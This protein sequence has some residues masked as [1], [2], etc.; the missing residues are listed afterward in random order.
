MYRAILLSV[1]LALPSAMAQ[2][3][4]PRLF[5]IGGRH[6]TANRE[7]AFREVKGRKLGAHLAEKF[8]GKKV[9]ILL[10][11]ETVPMGGLDEEARKMET[12]HEAILEG[13]LKG[14]GGKLEVAGTIAP[15]MPDDVKAK[16]QKAM[17][18]ADGMMM[19]EGQPWFGVNELNKE[20]EP[21][22]DKYDVLVCLAGLPGVEAPMLGARGFVPVTKLSAMKD[23]KVSIAI[24]DGGVSRFA[25][26]IAGKK[27]VAVVSWRRNMKDE[28]YDRNPGK[29]LDEAFGIRFVLI[30][31]EN[32]QEHREYFAW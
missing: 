8:P 6:A 3:L 29:D 5:G 30:T 26:A 20:L 13:L 22:Q 25:R 1:C 2:G 19:I 21:Y 15:K 9:V 4:I 16:Y 28:D 23:P 32:V 31:P 10:P 17:T 12:P 11:A 27:V 7:R 18:S 14:L 24:A